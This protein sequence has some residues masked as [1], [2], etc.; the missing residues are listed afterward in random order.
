MGYHFI[1]WLFLSPFQRKN[2]KNHSTAFWIWSNYM[3]SISFI[4]IPDVSHKNHTKC[5][6]INLKICSFYFP[7]F[8]SLVIRLFSPLITII[9]TRPN[10]FVMSEPW[11]LTATAL[12]QNRETQRS[13]TELAQIQVRKI[14]STAPFTHRARE[15]EDF[16]YFWKEQMPFA[17]V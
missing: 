1:V 6:L 15:R 17:A 16:L 8:L 14:H 9:H 4:Y 13:G 2:F 3:F 7:S 10:D 5:R 12:S 11:K